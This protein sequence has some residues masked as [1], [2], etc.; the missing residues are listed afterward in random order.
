MGYNIRLDDLVFGTV[1]V[2]NVQQRYEKARI[3]YNENSKGLPELIEQLKLYE[4]PFY[5][6]KENEDQINLCP[7]QHYEIDLR[8]ININENSN[9]AQEVYK[10][11]EIVERYLEAKKNQLVID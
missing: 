10:Q 7:N 8:N 3:I 4:V 2:V 5:L 1:E 9:F 6:L 11:K